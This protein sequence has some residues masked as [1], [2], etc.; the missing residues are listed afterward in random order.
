MQVMDTGAEDE[1]SNISKKSSIAATMLLKGWL[2]HTLTL[3]GR[4]QGFYGCGTWSPMFLLLTHGR[5][6]QP[7]QPTTN[8]NNMHHTK[9][10]T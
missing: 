4:L 8:F 6:L 3:Y 1:C 2:V 5:H 7:N 10:L 9:A